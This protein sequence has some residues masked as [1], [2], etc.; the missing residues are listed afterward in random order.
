MTSFQGQSRF[1]NPQSYGGGSQR[2]GTG[3]RDVYPNGTTN[4]PRMETPFHVG[5]HH[6]AKSTPTSEFAHPSHDSVTPDFPCPIYS[7]TATFLSSEIVHVLGM[8]YISELSQNVNVEVVGC[9]FWRQTRELKYAVFGSQ[10]D[11]QEFEKQL[12]RVVQSKASNRAGQEVIYAV[13]QSMQ[14][15]PQSQLHPHYPLY[16]HPP[17]AVTQQPTTV[18]SND[19]DALQINEVT[20]RYAQEFMTEEIGAIESDCQVR[21]LWSSAADDGSARV[22]VTANN[23]ESDVETAKCQLMQLCR[24]V[25]STM[26]EVR[27]SMPKGVWTALNQQVNFKEHG[28]LMMPEESEDGTTCVIVGPKEQLKLI[29]PKVERVFKSWRRPDD[30]LAS[31]SIE[32]RQIKVKKGDLTKE[33]TDAI[34]NAANE[35]LKHSGGVAKAI[36]DVGGK[37]IQHESDQIIQQK[38]RIC[39][40]QAI[41]TNSGNLSCKWV[42]HTVAPYWHREAEADTLTKLRQACANA[43][44]VASKLNVGSVALPGLGS[45]IYGIPKDKCAASLFEATKLFFQRVPASPITEVVFINI[46][47]ET[48]EAFRKE[49][50]KWASENPI[51]GKREH[52]LENGNTTV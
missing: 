45:G 14:S 37:T 13:R 44:K 11:I 31:C 19:P 41:H 4:L 25:S 34:V 5:A 32:D 52:P 3:S 18:Q 46:D 9:T 38:G 43:L 30:C 16:D 36:C 22:T 8:M 21:L 15:L 28:T 20:S 27:L 23:S 33:A 17:S 39:T 35:G 42:I 1:S 24:G 7:G 29:K 6:T 40:G 51:A 47:D 49:C 50:M 2:F 48:T 10:A 26:D 12:I